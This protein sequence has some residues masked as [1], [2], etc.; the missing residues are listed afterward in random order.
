M[1]T[2]NLSYIVT[3]RQSRFFFA[4]FIGWFVFREPNFRLR[5]LLASVTIFGLYLTATG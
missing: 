2:E 5:L 1:K 3:L 4:V